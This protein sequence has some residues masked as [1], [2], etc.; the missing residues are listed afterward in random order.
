MLSDR[1][2]TETQKFRVFSE[3]LSQWEFQIILWRE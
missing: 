3:S 2:L 1:K